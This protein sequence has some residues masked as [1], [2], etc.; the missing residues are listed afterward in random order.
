MASTVYN[1]LVLV[2]AVQLPLNIYFKDCT[3][4]FHLSSDILELPVPGVGLHLGHRP[5]GRQSGGVAV[6]AAVQDRLQQG[7]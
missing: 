1:M 3:L 2:Y 7:L 4:K 5:G 6:G